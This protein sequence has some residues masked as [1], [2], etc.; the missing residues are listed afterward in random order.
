MPKALLHDKKKMKNYVVFGAVILFMVVIFLV[1][2]IRIK[3]GLNAG[4]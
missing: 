3:A 1:T 4:S 2:V